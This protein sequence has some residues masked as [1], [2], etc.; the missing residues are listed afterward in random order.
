MGAQMCNRTFII[1]VRIFRACDPGVDCLVLAIISVAYNKL[2]NTTPHNTQR[3]T[4]N[5]TTA[6]FGKMQN[7]LL[8][9]VMSRN[10]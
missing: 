2:C 7:A 4:F 5:M 3:L 1:N 9:K 8:D 6:Y 10:Q